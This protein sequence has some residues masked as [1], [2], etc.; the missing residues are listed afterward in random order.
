MNSYHYKVKQSNPKKYIFQENY[1]YKNPVLSIIKLYKFKTKLFNQ[2][3][4]LKVKNPI[5]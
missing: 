5:F 4:K 1:Y 3:K 2:E